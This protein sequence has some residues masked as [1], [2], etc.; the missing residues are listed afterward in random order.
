MEIKMINGIPTRMLDEVVKTNGKTFKRIEEGNDYYV[1][2]E[3][4]DDGTGFDKEYGNFEVFLKKY[5][6]KSKFDKNADYSQIE[7][8][9]STSE[10]GKRAWTYTQ[11]KYLNKFIEN[12]FS[13]NISKLG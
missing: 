1:Y 9:P 10:W 8:Y 3:I 12:K 13:N 4:E 6:P 2:A 5:K 11:K 7:S